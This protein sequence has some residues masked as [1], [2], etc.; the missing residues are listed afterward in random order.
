[1]KSFGTSTR[2]ER[3]SFFFGVI[4]QDI[5]GASFFHQ[6]MILERFD[7]NGSVSSKLNKIKCYFTAWFLCFSDG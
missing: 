2:F 5:K 1:V 6:G 7:S 3:E 4:K